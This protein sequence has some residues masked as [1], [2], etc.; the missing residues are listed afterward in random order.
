MIHRKMFFSI[1]G[2]SDFIPSMVVGGSHEE[3]SDWHFVLFR[4]VYEGLPGLL[5]HV[6]V[7]DHHTFPRHEA[8]ICQSDGL[9]F[10]S[11]S[12]IACHNH[13]IFFK[14]FSYH[15]FAR[16]LF[17]STLTK[18]DPEKVFYLDANHQG[19]GWARRDQSGRRLYQSGV[20]DGWLEGGEV[21][22]GGGGATQELLFWGSEWHFQV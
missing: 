16:S 4:Q 18:C 20:G 1:V 5:V 7:V 14:A 15:R 2:A 13:T 22:L 21:V 11:S 3:A 8:L 6:G 9:F 19:D 10:P 12:V 17:K